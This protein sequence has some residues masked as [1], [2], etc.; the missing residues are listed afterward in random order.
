MLKS[1]SICAALI[2]AA[3]VFADLARQGRGLVV[4]AAWADL[5]VPAWAGLAVLAWAGLAVP[6]G[7]FVV[8]APWPLLA[9]GEGA[10]PVRAGSLVLAQ[11]PGR[12]LG[13]AEVI[14]PAPGGLAIGAEGIG[15]VDVSG[16]GGWALV[17]SRWPPRGRT[18]V[19]M[20][21]VTMVVSGGYPTMAG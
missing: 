16:P 1:V 5:A 21:T 12:V 17:P 10:S 3:A 20:A 19:V 11:G 6:A 14:G 9:L 13:Q 7:G 4:A 15:A 8:L 18:T 2:V